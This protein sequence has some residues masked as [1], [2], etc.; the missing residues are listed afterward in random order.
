MGELANILWRYVISTKD[1]PRYVKATTSPY[2]MLSPSETTSIGS[3]SPPTLV[4]YDSK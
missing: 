1:V 3:F 2:S 4:T